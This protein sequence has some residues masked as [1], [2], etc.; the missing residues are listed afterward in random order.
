MCGMH[1]SHSSL[2]KYPDIAI[3][4]K[5]GQ[6]SSNSCSIWESRVSAWREEEK[7]AAR[8]PGIPVPQ[9]QD[10]CTGSLTLNDGEKRSLTPGE[11]ERERASEGVVN[12]HGQTPAIV[13]GPDKHFQ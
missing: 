6:L 11:R 10:M 12:R 9:K 13:I 4:R 2:C 3:T 5:E 1:H 8:I 7:E